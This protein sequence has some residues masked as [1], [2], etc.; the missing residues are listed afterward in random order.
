[1]T[2]SCYFCKTF[3]LQVNLIPHSATLLPNPTRGKSSALSAAATSST[4]VG[5]LILK[6]SGAHNRS[7]FFYS[8]IGASPQCAATFSTQ[9]L[10][11]LRVLSRFE[12]YGVKKPGPLEIFQ[13][14]P[15]QPLLALIRESSARWGKSSCTA[16]ATCSTWVYM[17]TCVSTQV[18]HAGRINYK[19]FWS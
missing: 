9:V 15:M 3:L 11:L 7:H 12:S 8:R 2:F 18:A 6:A 19:F 14:S 16:I 5:M 17:C 4:Q 13:S 10:G 1:M